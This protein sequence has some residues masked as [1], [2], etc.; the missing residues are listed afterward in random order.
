MELESL[1]YETFE[2]LVALLLRRANYGITTHPAPPGTRAKN[3]G[4]VEVDF[5]ALGPS[6]QLTF[7]EV[8]HT[9]N[10]RVRPNPSMMRQVVDRA[11]RLQKLFPHSAFLFVYSGKMSASLADRFRGN[12]IDIWDRAEIGQYL[13]ENSDISFLIEKAS[14][15][16]DLSPLLVDDVAPQMKSVTDRVVDQLARVRKGK[17]GWRAFESTA[18]QVLAEIFIHQLEPPD[19]QNRTD[20]TLDIMD[21][22]FPIPYSGSPWSALRNEF[23]TRFVV[24]EFKNYTHPVGQCEVESIAQYLL[25]KAFRM[26]GLLVSRQTPGD[27]ALRARRRAWLEHDKVIVFLSDDDLISMAQIVDEKADPFIIIESQLTDF[28]RTL[29]I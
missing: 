13:A 23:R 5:T 22:I 15:N 29:S 1:D 11:I 6:G 28:F 8:K 17:E 20:D 21:A 14:I 18:T 24:A 10:P 27:P 25:P 16:R 4:G 7:V 19:M 26:L 9:R 12:G 2:A 3:A